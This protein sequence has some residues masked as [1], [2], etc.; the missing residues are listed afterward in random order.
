MG[1]WAWGRNE[2]LQVSG[3]HASPGPSQGET[4]K[5]IM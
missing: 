1:V 2:G 5:T 3:G 4:M